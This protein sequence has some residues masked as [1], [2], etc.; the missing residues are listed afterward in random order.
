MLSKLCQLSMPGGN[1]LRLKSTPGSAPE[2]LTF[3][4]LTVLVPGLEYSTPLADFIVDSCGRGKSSE[5][6]GR[7]YLG[8]GPMIRE[9]RW[10]SVSTRERVDF[11]GVVIRM[12]EIVDFKFSSSEG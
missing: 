1:T 4:F 12:I 11:D 2:T 6:P 9:K 3:S 7:K 5:M 10:T 8:S